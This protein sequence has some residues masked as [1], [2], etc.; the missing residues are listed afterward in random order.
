[1][2]T[3]EGRVTEHIE[4]RYGGSIKAAVAKCR[5]DNPGIEIESINGREVAGWCE[6]CGSP[7]FGESKYYSDQDGVMWCK[8]HGV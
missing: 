8:S 5:E 1:M 6:V 2:P 4:E 3:I 7:L